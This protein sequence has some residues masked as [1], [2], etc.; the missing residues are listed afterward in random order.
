M[1]AEI[2]IVGRTVEKR[3][4]QKIKRSLSRALRN[5]CFFALESQSARAMTLDSDSKCLLHL[6]NRFA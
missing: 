4:V 6:T 2:D 1:K 3:L 5:D